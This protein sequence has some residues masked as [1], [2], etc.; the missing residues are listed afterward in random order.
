MNSKLKK[1]I[2]AILL[3]YPKRSF[4][5]Q[6]LAAMTRGSIRLVSECLR[7]L[8]AAEVTEAATKKGRRYYRLNPYF[9]LLHELRD[10]VFDPKP[11]YDD[12]VAKLLRQLP[13]ARMIVLS[14][15]FTLAPHLPVDILLIGDMMNRQ[16]LL[17]TMEEIEGLTGQEVNY[18]LLGRSE[19]QERLYMNDRL[20]RDV[21]DNP[22]IV[23]LNTFR[24]T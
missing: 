21:L 15:V 11:R 16:K 7:E 9:P 14:G 22:H 23:V 12:G 18:A 8:T 24:K 10:L 13:E 20:L 17:R 2:L 1:E 19:Y 4:S 6:E 3:L 5:P